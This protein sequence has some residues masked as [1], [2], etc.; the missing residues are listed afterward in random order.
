MSEKAKEEAA[1]NLDEEEFISKL[2]EE[3]PSADEFLNQVKE[4]VKKMDEGVKNTVI[5]CTS[6][7]VQKVQQWFMSAMASYQLTLKR[8]DQDIAIAKAAQ[9]LRVMVNGAINHQRMPVILKKFAGGTIAGR[10][11]TWVVLQMTVNALLVPQ[12]N[13]FVAVIENSDNEAEVK[14]AEYL[15][16]SATAVIKIFSAASLQECEVAFKFDIWFNKGLDWLRKQFD[17]H[18]EGFNDMVSNID[19]GEV[20]DITKD[21]HVAPKVNTKIFPGKNGKHRHNR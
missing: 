1:V 15:A 13:K 5:H 18:G 16:K 17:S 19:I 10:V 3:L 20:I 4:E 12:I 11:A 8:P 14:R 2:E 7:L 9:N 6:K 21:T